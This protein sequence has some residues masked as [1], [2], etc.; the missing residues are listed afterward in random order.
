M[1][2]KKRH[3]PGMVVRYI[4][5]PLSFCVGYVSEKLKKRGK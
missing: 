5:E 3:I 2:N 1:D 4:F